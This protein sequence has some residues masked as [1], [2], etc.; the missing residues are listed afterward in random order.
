MMAENEPRGQSARGEKGGK[1]A[2]A[3]QERTHS[4][5]ES[6]GT[7]L[8][9]E[10]V[11]VPAAPPAP[12]RDDAPERSREQVRRQRASRLPNDDDL[13]DARQG[14][15]GDGPGTVMVDADPDGSAD[16]DG[17]RRVE[18]VFLD[19]SGKEAGRE[20]FAPDDDDSDRRRR[21]R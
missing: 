20:P 18:L 21:P 3:S 15:F 13:E 4:E 10:S 5:P 1:S 8:T 14:R 12:G 16:D 9:A 2:S 6:Q 11:R 17:R 7:P 19:G